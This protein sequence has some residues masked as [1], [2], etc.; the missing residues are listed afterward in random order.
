MKPSTSG[1]TAKL[2]GAAGELE[3]RMEKDNEGGVRVER[4]VR[5]W[6][7]EHCSYQCPYYMDGAVLSLCNK[8]GKHLKYE[9]MRPALLPEC[10]AELDRA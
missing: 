7:E 4:P 9:G 6:D 10:R 5:R 1:L 8:F 2:T 3:E